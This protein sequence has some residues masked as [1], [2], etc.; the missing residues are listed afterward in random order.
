MSVKSP[1]NLTFD[2]GASRALALVLGVV[3]A[4]AVAIASL[5]PIVAT[6]RLALIGAVALSLYR[7]L[8][9]HAL[10]RPRAA[11]VALTLADDDDCALRRRDAGEQE[12]GRLIDRWVHPW[13]SILVIR[14]HGRRWPTSVVIA[15]DAMPAEA[16]RRL[17]VRLLQQRATVSKSY[18]DPHSADRGKGS[19]A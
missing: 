3:H 7:G 18:R 4:G 11:V 12:D 5:L 8:R 15:A 14:T 19:R 6:L 9:L 1:D 10:R 2:L 17:R 16:F 13:L